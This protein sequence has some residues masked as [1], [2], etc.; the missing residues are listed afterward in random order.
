[1]ASIASLAEFFGWCTVIN[2]GLLMIS[3]L[4]VAAARSWVTG[5]HSKLFGVPEAELP[6]VYFRYLAWYKIGILL[7]NLVPWVALKIMS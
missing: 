4:F 3:F 2:F 6:M 1:M 7:F 5:L